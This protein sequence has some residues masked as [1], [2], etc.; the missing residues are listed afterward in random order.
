[1]PDPYLELKREQLYAEHE[2]TL[3]KLAMLE[4]AAARGQE[5]ADREKELERDGEYAVTPRARRGFNKAMDRAFSRKRVNIAFQTT[6]KVFPKVAAV[7][8]IGLVVL[9]GLVLSVEA[10]R[11]K[12]LT[13]LINVQD[14]FG[15]IGGHQEDPRQGITLRKTYAPTYIPEEYTLSSVNG[16]V[17]KSVVYLND[18][19]LPIAFEEYSENAAAN[20]DTEN[21]LVQEIQIGGQPGLSIEKEDM[22]TVIWNGTDRVFLVMTK[23]SMEE[24][25][26]I[27][28]SVE[29]IS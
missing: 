11:V 20:I 18:D 21:A 10:V 1:M 9:G 7:F 15:S 14:G 6:A 5:W 4:Y 25:V 19:G 27:A 29:Y 13:F 22:F 16:S 12:T 8:L 23:I 26:K 3:F 2:E 28:E 24:T 17:S